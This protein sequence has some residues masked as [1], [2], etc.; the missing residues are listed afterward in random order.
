[1]SQRVVLRGHSYAQFKEAKATATITPGNL[2][3]LDATGGCAPNTTT[4]DS[5]PMIAV[6]DGYVGSSSQSTFLNNSGL[7]IDK[8][9]ISGD[10]VLYQP[11]ITGCEFLATNPSSAAAIAYG[12]F[13]AADGLG[14]LIAT[15]AVT[16]FVARAAVNNSAGATTVRVRTEV[17]N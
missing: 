4:G 8:Q 3:Q 2:I 17:V 10:Q 16:K 11:L 9:Y 5:P 15:T 13:L 1:M 14:N 7:A 12:S 6:E